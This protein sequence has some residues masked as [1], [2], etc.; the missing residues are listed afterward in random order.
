MP[1]KR[2]K[3]LALLAFVFAS[4]GSVNSAKADIL[5]INL[6]M[7]SSELKAAQEAAALRGEK[8]IVIPDAPE[9][10]RTEY[11]SLTQKLDKLQKQKSS[12]KRDQDIEVVQKQLEPIR[13][14]YSVS[15][16]D[17]KSAVSK[18]EKNGS[19]ISAFII[20]GHNSQGAFWGDLGSVSENDLQSVVSNHPAFGKSVTGVFLW[21]CYA[22]SITT[23]GEWKSIFPNANLVLGFTLSAA[24]AWNPLSA[25]ML[26]DG[27]VKENTLA[28]QKTNKDLTKCFRQVNSFLNGAAGAIVNQCYVSTS[29][30]ATS[31]DDVKKGCETGEKLLQDEEHTY[32][33]YYSAE[34]P[35]FENPPD[36]H[37]TASDLRKYY[38]DLHKWSHC[39]NDLIRR[40]VPLTLALIFFNNIEKNFGAYYR[41]EITAVNQILKAQGALPGELFPDYS[42]GLP[43]RKQALLHVNAL[44]NSNFS[45]LRP[46][47][48]KQLED[49]SAR[50]EKMIS[51]LYC[52]PPNWITETPSAGYPPVAPGC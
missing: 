24:S 14:K 40:E 41:K 32:D 42:S 2:N 5:F 48:R 6:H 35:G 22:G 36:P 46:A 29:V 34:D 16:E 43:T 17:I 38:A 44:S 7:S 20:S 3:S 31:I 39:D 1:K 26:K 15:V 52:E 8:V 33:K 37:N 25:Q 18:V 10:V 51:A 50:E 45:G 4:L 13:T 30:S 21:G 47:E 12:D 49:L 27:L 23:A 28:S 9:S 11:G 19:K